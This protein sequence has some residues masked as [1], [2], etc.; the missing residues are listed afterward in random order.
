M[1]I[2]ANENAISAGGYQISNS[3]RFQSASSQYLTRTPAS[4]T[5]RT[6]WTWS[7]WVKRGALGIDGTFFDAAS[8]DQF[9]WRSDDTFSVTF[10]NTLAIQTTQVFR[11]PSAWYHFVVVADTTQA[12]ASNRI[13][14][15]VNGV[16]VTA[17]S[18]AS[19]PAQNTAGFIN[20][21][22]AHNLGRVNSGA[23]YFDGYMTE[24]NFIDGQAL[25]P[26]SFGETD[27]LTGQWV[28]KKY[29]GTYGTNGFYLPFSNGT[30]TTT[31][32]NDSSGNGNN[33]T[34][35][36]FT[37]SAGVSDCWM[38][39]VP[40][41]NGGASGTQPNSNYCV[42]N[43]LDMPTISGM[44]ITN[45]NLNSASSSTDNRFHCR[46]TVGMTTGKW[47][48]E[49]TA[50]SGN[51]CQAGIVLATSNKNEYVGYDASGW[52]IYQLD[53]SKF[54]NQG[55]TSG[56]AYGSAWS[57]AND[58]LMTAFDADTGKIWWGK[59]GTW[60][61]SGDPVAG[62]NAAFSGLASNT[63][64]PA[65]GDGSGGGVYSAAINFGQR[66]FAFSPPTGYKA[67]CTANL[68]ASTIV[69]GNKYM[70]ATLY[71]GNG[72]GQSIVNAGGFKPDFVWV[73]DRSQ[74]SSSVLTDAVRGTDK[75]LFSNL[76][77]AEQTN[78]TYVTSFNS[79]GFTVGVG[80][81]GTGIVNNTTPDAFVGWQWQ[82]GQ[83][84]TS[85]NTNGSITSTVSVNATAG[86]SIVTY[87]GTGANATVGHGLGVAPKMVIVKWRSGGGLSAQDWDVY[88][89]SVGA[90]ARLFLNTTAASATTS[91][92]WNNTAPTSSVFSIGTGTDV[93]GNGAAYV[94]YCFAEISGFS[95]AFSYTGNGSADGTMVYCGFQPKYILIKANAGADWVIHDA[96]RNP[97][98]V[99]DKSLYANTS[100]AETT[101]EP[102][103]ILSN[104]FKIRSTAGN[105]NNNG[106]TYIGIAFAS[107]PFQNSNAF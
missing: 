88:H 40:S 85:S 73:K 96:T 80:T 56:T 78:S 64:F 102:L 27:T 100:G 37:R 41:G 31:L 48:W 62:T 26:S 30:S 7:G 83:G 24:V 34:L 70:D 39:D 81:S 38:K 107:N 79:N 74:V 1:G 8:N 59:N 32:G 19:Y 54:Y 61:A 55:G 87:T 57:S 69:K 52:G 3:L 28:A 51:R 36:N 75:Q 93:N 13:K 92:A 91:L 15:Y 42:L 76:T 60:F 94:A 98:N 67:L 53:G 12:T 77:N 82:A 9:R 22:N 105:V 45:A 106:T 63:Y 46:S 11:D 35:N 16:Q 95:K 17:F 25:T 84:S 97:Y 49:V 6:T 23:Y 29:T 104:G 50:I 103:D 18:T 89:A 90:T 71:T 20:S 44:T 2:L 58:V 4:A 65:I 66:S 33:W 101:S 68:P 47:Y 5:N 21:V 43:P 72:T 86:F 10:N 99:A 14:L